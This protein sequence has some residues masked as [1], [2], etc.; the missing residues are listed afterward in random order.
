MQ[1]QIV[2]EYSP[3]ISQVCIPNRVTYSIEPVTRTDFSFSRKAGVHEVQVNLEFNLF[4]LIIDRDESLWVEANIYLLDRIKN[5]LNPVMTTY[6]CIASDLLTYKLFLDESELNWKV[7]ERNKLQRPTYRYRAYL[8]LLVECGELKSSTARRKMGAIIS[9]YR[10]LE[11]QELI[12]PEYPMWKESDAYIKTTNKYGASF[13]K[14]IKSTD[15]S[16]KLTDASN[17]YNS[18]IKDTGNLRPLTQYEQEWLLSSLLT[19]N[20][21][22]MYLIHLIALTTG[23]R[24]QSILTLRLNHVSTN[25]YSSDLIDIKIPA[26][27]GTGIDTK[28]NKKIIL[29][30]PIWVYN[31]LYFYALSENANSRRAKSVLGNSHNQY[32]FL[33]NRG[34]P[35]YQSRE[36]LQVF[37][38]DLSVHHKKDGQA[39]RQYIKDYVLPYIRETYQKPNF[40][41]HFHDLR[42]TFGMNLTD[43]QLENV[44]KGRIS[45]HEAR[46]FVRVRMCHESSAT[47]DLYLQ[48]RHKL[49]HIHEV[50]N[51]YN[52]HLQ[53]IIE[54]YEGE[55]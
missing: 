5:S 9:F 36:D 13:S 53:R 8:M 10:W 31:K 21:Y 49:E 46:E 32:L 30:M 17:P 16:I 25:M 52:K 34:T 40:S 26:G 45:L 14:K 55:S 54:Q 11:Q 27:P 3:T 38:T 6:S 12:H 47:T 20:N 4:P 43:S 24:I 28:Y 29:H 22:E 2:D 35:Y 44:A 48:Y 23:A 41:Y 50:S 1:T 37:K 33:T 39:I 15:I 51:S 42:A 18:T 19:L 7:F